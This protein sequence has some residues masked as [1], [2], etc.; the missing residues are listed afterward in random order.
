[1]SGVG[2]ERCLGRLLR[3]KELAMATLFS[4]LLSSIVPLLLNLLLSLFFNG[5]TTAV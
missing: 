5:G 1:M 4:G 2:F 3:I